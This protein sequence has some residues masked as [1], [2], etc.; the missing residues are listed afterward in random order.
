MQLLK[1]IKQ[2]LQHRLECT[3]KATD[4][5]MIVEFGTVGAGLWWS[6][7]YLV[8]FCQ[9]PPEALIYSKK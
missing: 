4:M 6:M 8:T 7:P 3:D 5:E 2:I 9:T 1:E